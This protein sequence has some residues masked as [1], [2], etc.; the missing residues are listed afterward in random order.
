MPESKSKASAPSGMSQPPQWTQPETFVAIY[1]DSQ[2]FSNDDVANIIRTKC[3]RVRTGNQV[4]TR[5]NNVLRKEKKGNRYLCDETKNPRKWNTQV[6]DEY[7]QRIVPNADL[8]DKYKSMG[9]STPA[10]GIPKFQASAPNIAAQSSYAAAA[11]PS[12]QG[13]GFNPFVTSPSQNP[14][15]GRYGATLDKD[16]APATSGGYG[17]GAIEVHHSAGVSFGSSAGENDGA[18]P[19]LVVTTEQS[20]PAP[21]KDIEQEQVLMVEEAAG[22]D[23]D[24]KYTKI[25]AGDA[26]LVK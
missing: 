19:V 7:L 3:G 4:E 13:P 23:A 22:E 15:G 25:D 2:G 18:T 8:R 21:V 17:S 16:G 12:L 24:G 6:V 1:F 26:G 14:E 9:L 10:L 11:P 5:I 20:R